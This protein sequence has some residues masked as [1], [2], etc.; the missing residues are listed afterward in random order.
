MCVG[1]VA[2]RQTGLDVWPYLARIQEACSRYR[3][4]YML[5]DAVRYA[6][7]VDPSWGTRLWQSIASETIFDPQLG[8][9]PVQLLEL[10]VQ[11]GDSTAQTIVELGGRGALGGDPRQCLRAAII[12]VV[13]EPDPSKKLAYLDS[14]LASATRPQDPA[15]GSMF[16]GMLIADR[17]AWPSGKST[18]A[19]ELLARVLQTPACRRSAAGT[20]QKYK[21]LQVSKGDEE[22]WAFLLSESERAL[23]D[24]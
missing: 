17:A 24:R 12:C 6:R 1:E 19:L 20:I 2:L 9:A 4:T 21:D 10:F 5:I 8:E 23:D 7:S 18:P 15:M 3:E 16:V 11:E 14:V 22:L 13:N